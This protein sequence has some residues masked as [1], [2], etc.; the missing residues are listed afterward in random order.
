MC[1]AVV[2]SLFCEHQQQWSRHHHH[3]ERA[4][5]PLCAW[6]WPTRSLNYTDYSL[7]VSGQTS[8]LFFCAALLRRQWRQPANVQKERER[9]ASSLCKSKS[10]SRSPSPSQSRS[11]GSNSSGR[12]SRL[13]LLAPRRF[14]FFVRSASRRS[15]SQHEINQR[16]NSIWSVALRRLTLACGAKDDLSC[17]SHHGCRFVRSFHG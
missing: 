17:F 6:H 13:L 15:S 14:V 4:L 11:S 1:A 8:L 16:Y 5:P 9:E 10:Q 12:G 3:N 7:C 2:L